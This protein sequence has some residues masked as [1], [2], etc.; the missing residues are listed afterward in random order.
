MIT[1]LTPAAQKRQA[2]RNTQK[3][4]ALSELEDL[5]YEAIA[6]KHY[7]IGFDYAKTA[8]RVAGA[9]TPDSLLWEKVQSIVGLRQHCETEQTK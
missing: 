7:S 3:L 9:V 8:L 5:I 2:R 6:A 1:T 4:A